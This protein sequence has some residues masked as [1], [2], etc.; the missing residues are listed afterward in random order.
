VTADFTIPENIAA[1][2]PAPFNRLRVIKPDGDKY[3]ALDM[4]GRVI[5]MMPPTSAMALIE[6]VSA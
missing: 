3:V 2:L 6:R 1:S 5:A 4:T